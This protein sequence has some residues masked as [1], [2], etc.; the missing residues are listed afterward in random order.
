EYTPIIHPSRVRSGHK[1]DPQMCPSDISTRHH[2]NSAC[3][4]GASIG[5]LG[6]RGLIRGS[7]HRATPSRWLISIDPV[8]RHV[9]LPGRDPPENRNRK[10]LPGAGLAAEMKPPEIAHESEVA[11]SAACRA[12]GGTRLGHA[13]EAMGLTPGDAF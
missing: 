11:T 9:I 10:H 6:C 4:T 1:R 2:S 12:R 5:L 7:P 3:W 13:H 8:D